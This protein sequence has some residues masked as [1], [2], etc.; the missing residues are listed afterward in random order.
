MCARAVT[1]RRRDKVFADKLWNRF[2]GSP[3]KPYM[4]QPRVKQGIDENILARVVADQVQPEV[5]I[6]NK[7]GHRHPAVTGMP[8]DGVG[9]PSDMQQTPELERRLIKEMF[10]KGLGATSG[11]QSEASA[12][13]KVLE[14]GPGI[15]VGNPL[16]RD[17][18]IAIKYH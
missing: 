18:R 4:F 2:K 3:D 10:P 11:T 13:R 6:T 9:R 15:G 16:L 14:A 1:P 5:W 7:L 8:I 17:E 12:I